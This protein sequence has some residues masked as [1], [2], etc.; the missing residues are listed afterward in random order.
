VQLVPAFGQ[1]MQGLVV[2]V[3]VVWQVAN[4]ILRLIAAVIM[5]VFS[6]FSAV[7]GF[8]DL[9]GLVGNF[10]AIFTSL[11][12]VFTTAPVIPQQVNF[13]NETRSQFRARA[14]AYFN[15]TDP[16]TFNRSFTDGISALLSLVWDYDTND[17]MGNFSACACRNLVIDEAVCNNVRDRHS[18][19]LAAPTGPVL[20]AV[21]DTMQGSTFCDHH[22]GH[23]NDTL[24]RWED[25][26]H[27]DRAYY[28]ECMEKVIQG[29]RL[30]DANPAI[31]ADMF[32]R[33]EGPMHFWEN[34]RKAAIVGVRQ[35]HDWVMGRR[36]QVQRVLPDD[37]YEQ[38]WAKRNEYIKRW[39]R[40]HPRWRKSLL[41][42]GLTQIDQY[43]YKFRTGFYMPMIRKALRN[44]QEGNIP[45]V[46][47]QE[48]FAI[49]A[50]HLPTIGSNLIQIQIRQAASD[51]YDGLAA[52]PAA[53]DMFSTRSVW[54]IYWEAVERTHAQPR[55]A[56]K[57]QAHNE[58]RSIIMRSLR[59][60]PVYQW[61]Y[62]NWTETWAPK[63]GPLRENPFTR[64]ADHLRRV[65]VWQRA[66]AENTPSTIVN[67]DLHMRQRFAAWWE[68]RF[69]SDRREQ[70]MA[71][72]GSAGRIW[73]RV[74]NRIW[75]G[76]VDEATVR[77]FN[78]GPNCNIT[79]NK[80]TTVDNR[81]A[82][83]VE[84]AREQASGSSSRR[85]EEEAA[86]AVSRGGHPRVGGWGGER[87]NLAQGIGVNCSNASQ[88]M[89]D[90]M[91]KRTAERGF[92]IGGNCLLF[93]GFIDELVFLVGYC[94]NQYKPQLP[95][96][97]RA[98]LESRDPLTSSSVWK[99]LLALSERPEFRFDNPDTTVWVQSRPHET[100]DTWQGWATWLRRRSLDWVRPKFRPF[101]PSLRKKTTAREVRGLGAPEKTI[102]QLYQELSKQQWM[103]AGLTGY[104]WIRASSGVTSFDLFTWF[105]G[106]IDD[107]FGTS[108]GQAITNFLQ[109]I[110]DWFHNPN[111]AYFP[112]PVGWT[113]WSKM[114]LRCQVEPDPGEDPENAFINLNC[115]V[116]IGLESAIGY[117]T[118]YMVL[119]YIVCAVFIPPLT[120][121]FTTIPVLLVY[122][123]VVPM[124]AWHY[125][126]RC[127]LM[128][129]A[130]IL[131]GSGS[132]GLSVPYYP[133]PIAFPALPF[134]LMDE[135]TALIIKYTSFC[136]CQIWWGT[137]LE[138][139]CPPYAVN[140]NPCPPCPER[141]SI[142]NCNAIGLGGGIDTAIYLSIWLVPASSRWIKGFAQIVFL[143]GHFG[144]TLASI[145]DYIYAA[146]DRFTDIPASQSQLF[147]W[148]FGLTLP[149]LA[150]VVLF[151]IIF[152]LVAALLWTLFN[153]L[154]GAV[155]EWIMSSPF[156]YIFGGA[157]TDRSAYDAFLGGE[158][159]GTL[160]GTSDSLEDQAYVEME[161][162]NLNTT[163]QPIGRRIFV[164]VRRR[165]GIR[166]SLL[167]DPIDRVIAQA[168]A[169]LKR[170][171]E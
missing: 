74:K 169:R 25:I 112:G 59:A 129:P 5:F 80:R 140:G 30:N 165:L 47:I 108:V 93:D 41:V 32:Y 105:I 147:G 160:S 27:S 65:F 139:I 146:A 155:W 109:N 145:G 98:Q 24:I 99:A 103:R 144:S 168:T 90:L 100:P 163:G 39:T 22:M 157:F 88:F 106:V 23:F 102:Q 66:Q 63:S 68:K 149:S 116:G 3:S 28:I 91:D 20:K 148:C 86:A 84:L 117:V 164:P 150:G 111:T 96:F 89:R 162:Q 72:W 10:V 161:P 35:E 64:L 138:F 31:P 76:S 126:P 127:W 55:E 9:L 134:C 121:L 120:G 77:R 122:A 46:S 43:E 6:L 42:V 170:Y 51:I 119:A 71:N 75:P 104:Q 62:S 44:I 53:L 1:I 54:S 125:S 158:G 4:P 19:G 107:W 60:S 85:R 45:R 130:L 33:H 128:T 12:S 154:V 156:P 115:K 40:A 92:I 133:F 37:V 143:S 50:N 18:R 141:I 70:V 67:A 151:F 78:I 69:Q 73:Y 21:A 132:L 113:Y 11:S 79:W 152:W 2:M 94:V 7:G 49:L 159:G 114:P 166:S 34:A 48:R 135:L 56:A 58:K 131:P 124:V 61:W 38:R 52:I 97:M 153:V 26:W 57:R 118:F 87:L 81:E 13:R 137:P 110:Q 123:I 15:G 101:D 82:I 16:D 136:W 8:F 17:C 83:E 95:P 36:Q 171:K 29:G 167:F 14:A 142:T